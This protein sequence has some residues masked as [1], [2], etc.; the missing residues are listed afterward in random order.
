MNTDSSQSIRNFT[1]KL[2]F[3]LWSIHHGSGSGI[4]WQW[5]IL[6]SNSIGGLTVHHN[7]SRVA[8]YFPP[9]KCI[10]KTV[11]NNMG[12][13]WCCT[14]YHTRKGENELE[15]IVNLHVTVFFHTL[16][17]EKISGRFTHLARSPNWCRWGSKKTPVL[18]T[19]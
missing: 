17:V 2:P 8:E 5:M 7:S 15:M 9:N 11:N 14:A 13:Q 4:C 3:L 18:E 1:F 16:S 10:H 19:S 12:W 6:P